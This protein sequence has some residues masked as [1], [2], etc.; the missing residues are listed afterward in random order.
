MVAPHGVHRYGQHE[1]AVYRFGRKA[2]RLRFRYF[3]YFTAFV[4]AAV[5]ANAVR[6]LGFMAIGTLRH[7][8]WAQRIVCAARGRAALGMAPFWIGHSRAP[9][10]LAPAITGDV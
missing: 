10:Q 6:Q 1:T 9:L 5:R 7:D 2:V 3:N 8:G 4:F